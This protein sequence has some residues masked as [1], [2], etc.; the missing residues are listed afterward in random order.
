MSTQ[1]FLYQLCCHG[2]WLQA[3]DC[4]R[5]QEAIKDI[6]GTEVIRAQLHQG[7]VLPPEHPSSTHSVSLFSVFQSD[8]GSGIGPS[9]Y[10]L[11]TREEMG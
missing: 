4:D 11:I 5:A 2:H 7:D 6:R 8:M 10:S 3:G 9:V 1:H